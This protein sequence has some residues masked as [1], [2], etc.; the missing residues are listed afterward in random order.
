MVVV[1]RKNRLFSVA[2][3]AAVACSLGVAPAR[4]QDAPHALEAVNVAEPTSGRCFDELGPGEAKRT[5]IIRGADGQWLSGTR[6]DLVG[7]NAYNTQTAHTDDTGKASFI[8]RPGTYRYEIY[9]EPG[10][11]KPRW[12]GDWFQV[13]E[14]EC[15]VTALRTQ[16]APTVLYRWPA[17]KVYPGEVA[18]VMPH[19]ENTVGTRFE[20]VGATPEWASVYSDGTVD[21]RPPVGTAPGRYEV[22]I[23]PTALPEATA[24][25]HVLPAP[26]AAQRSR[27]YYPSAFVRPGQTAKSLDPRLSVQKS[28]HEFVNQPIPAGTRF[29]TSFPGAQI[30][31]KTGV[32]AL[33]AAADEAPGTKLEIPVTATMPDE[34]TIQSTLSFEV[35]PPL[36]AEVHAPRYDAVRVAPGGRFIAAPQ[37]AQSLPEGTEFTWRSADNPGL[38]GWIASVDVRSGVLEA[39]VPA[40]I[41]QD[42][43]AVV[44]VSY[45]DGSASKLRVPVQVVEHLSE[46]ELA[47]HKLHYPAQ[48]VEPGTSVTVA[49]IGEPVYGTSYSVENDGGV[50][51]SVDKVSGTVTATIPSDAP[52]EGIYTS[53]IRAIFPG[54]SQLIALKLTA[55]SLAH[56]HNVDYLAQEGLARPKQRPKQARFALPKSYDSGVAS[57][58]VDAVSGEVRAAVPSD[59]QV[60]EIT[61]P[62]V[63]TWDD[64]S[65]RIVNVQ[66]VPKRN[67]S[68]LE[69]LWEQLWWL[70]PV[71]LAAQGLGVL[72]YWIW[73]TNKDTPGFQ[74]MTHALR[75]A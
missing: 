2:L 10:D 71:L 19:E 16:D 40:T 31:A 18:S 69:L 24:V 26:S 61:V 11:D 22:R 12:V 13:V 7:R 27:L 30:D 29:S 68:K 51:L 52:P 66:V 14:S 70:A 36:L 72:A 53:T 56:N 15:I 50:R 35:I 75:G 1:R 48:V 9:A 38:E 4:A 33:K 74:V 41:R 44:R 21:I 59:A 17:V 25:V 57:V 65:Q 20:K 46:E 54:G 39:I 73:E 32:V 62:V 5:F 60:A 63:V 28:A 47:K 67:K 43:E 34:S 64:G 55:D 8:I 58:Q 42:T 3:T 6:L 49:P 37:V 45:S 23:Q